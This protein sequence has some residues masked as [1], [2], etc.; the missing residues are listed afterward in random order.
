MRGSEFQAVIASNS[1][2]FHEKSSANRLE[3]WHRCRAILKEIEKAE[4]LEEAKA[5]AKAGLL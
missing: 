2:R 4:T 3:K 5:L 1:A